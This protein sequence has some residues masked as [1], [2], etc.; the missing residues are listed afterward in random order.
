MSWSVVDVDGRRKPS[1]YA[2]RRAFADRTIVLTP[3]GAGVRLTLVNDAATAWDDLLH[4]VALDADAS[5]V[6]EHR[7]AT[8]VDPD[9]AQH[10]ALPASLLPG[11]HPTSRWSWSRSATIAPYTRPARRHRCVRVGMSRSAA[12]RRGIDIDVT[13]WTLVRDLCCF[14]ERLDPDAVVDDQL[15]T[16]LAGESHRFRV[17]TRVVGVDGWREALGAERSLV[18][19][20]RRPADRRGVSVAVTRQRR[21][22]RRSS[23]AWRPRG[24]RRRP[25]GR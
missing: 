23:A 18:R 8:H 15:V 3:E 2:A 4:V 14:A 13:A 22:C 25:R 24:T 20:S 10:I 7:D 17:R 11:G 1:W 5:V 9:H 21:G 16:L 12:M 19:P 6:G